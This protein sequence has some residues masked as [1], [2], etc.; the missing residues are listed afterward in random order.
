MELLKGLY[1]KTEQCLAYHK[2]NKM[3]AI[4]ILEKYCGIWKLEK[5]KIKGKDF[6]QEANEN[7]IYKN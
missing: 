7:C 6:T 1:I 4:V 5:E 2:Q 3:L